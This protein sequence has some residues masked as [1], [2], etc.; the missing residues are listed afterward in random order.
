[1]KYIVLRTKM[2]GME[3]KI[4]IIFPNLLVHKHVAK[5]IT[6]LLIREYNGDADIT[7][8]SAGNIVLG[9]VSCSGSS[10]TCN[11]KSDIGDADLIESLD[12][13]NGITGA[14]TLADLG[15]KPK[16]RKKS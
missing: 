12:Y 7:I 1:M 16:R 8:A 13:T 14:F 3:Q 15:I 9:D 2:A 5:Y 11:S 4:P 6:G 10:E